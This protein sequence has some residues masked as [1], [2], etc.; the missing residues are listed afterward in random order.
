MIVHDV[1]VDNEFRILVRS[2][3]TEVKEYRS[4]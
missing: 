4:V 2:S 3:V 1:G